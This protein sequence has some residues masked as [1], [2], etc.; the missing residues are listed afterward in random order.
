MNAIYSINAASG[1]TQGALAQKWAQGATGLC[2]GYTSLVPAQIGGKLILFAFNKTTQQLDAYTLTGS[3][4]W[5]TQTPCKANLTG[6]PW[7][8]L[9]SFVLGN[10]RYLL[11]YRADSGGVVFFDVARELN[12][13]PAVIFFGSHTTPSE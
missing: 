13:T 3:D 12:L 7:D 6:G 8:T 10:V 9:N 2:A 11:T 1:T 5:V 4:P